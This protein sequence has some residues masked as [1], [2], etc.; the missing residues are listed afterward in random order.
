MPVAL[1]SD[2]RWRIV[3][4]HHYKDLCLKEIADLF[5]I[6][7]STVRRIL[8]KFDQSGD[9]SPKNGRRG[10]KRILRRREEFSIIDILL[11]NPAVYLEELQQELYNNTGTLASLSTIFRTVHRLRFTRKKIRHVSMQQDAVKREEFM[12]E[13]R[14]INAN[15]IVWLDESGADRR[16]AR[17]MFGYHLRGMTPVDYK[18]TFRGKRFSSIAIMSQRGL[19]DVDTYEGTINGNTF[20]DFIERCLVPIL[21]PFNGT[22]SRSVVVMDNASIHHVEEV[23]ATI[24]ATGAILR[25]LPPYSPDYNPLEESFAKVKA[26]LKANQ[27]AYDATLSPQLLIAMGFNSIST[28]DCHGYIKH[29]GYFIT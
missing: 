13:M 25:F 2:V 4:L 12:E 15:M 21:Q 1:S 8:N 22:N 29:S 17:R 26:F 6:H 28:Q 3:W 16:S 20:C 11:N 10:P 23:V 14:Y 19:E 27:V 24:E 18:F 5:Y 7:I 9:V